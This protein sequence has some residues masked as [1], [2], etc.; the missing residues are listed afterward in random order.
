[1]VCSLLAGF[2]LMF[3]SRG[4]PSYFGRVFFLMM[5]A[6]FAPLAITMANPIWYHHPCEFSLASAAFEMVAW[7]IAAIVLSAFVRPPR[8]VAATAP[9][10]N[11]K[12]PLRPEDFSTR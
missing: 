6:V 8:M 1:V 2:M 10:R 4:L 7:F 9:V 12:P 5:L 11:T 3:A